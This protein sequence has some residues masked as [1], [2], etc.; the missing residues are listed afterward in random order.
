MGTLGPSKS[1]VGFGR[2]RNGKVSMG[3]L[4]SLYRAVPFFT[5]HEIIL[6]R[7]ANFFGGGYRRLT[8]CVG[9]LPSCLCLIFTRA[10]MSGEGHVCGTMGTYKDVTRFV[11]RSR[12]A[13]V[14]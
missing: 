6:L 5:R 3:R 7:S 9:R 12:G 13:L 2:C 11:E 14:H 1:A 10:R 8:S 4:V